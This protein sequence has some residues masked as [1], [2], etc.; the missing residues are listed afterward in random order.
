MRRIRKEAT[1]VW[2]NPE[3]VPIRA[4]SGSVRGEASQSN[5]EL[6]G[7]QAPMG[8]LFSRHATS[9]ASRA[10]SAQP[11][12]RSALASGRIVL[13]P[14]PPSDP[15]TLE[16]QRL[17]QRLLLA[18]GRP[19]VSKAA[20]EYIKAGYPLPEDQDVYLQ[21][22]EHSDEAVVRDAITS[23]GNLLAQE[24]P[25]RRAVLE[26]RL[27]RIEQFAEEAPTQRQAEQLRR[28]VGGHLAD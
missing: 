13:A 20:N 1:K 16:R 23:L 21:L 4:N 17:L 3:I 10:T 5:R 6:S 28:S 19:S 27:R 26:S 9:D 2:Y 12:T 15:A 22:L 18:E 8:A 14:P 24:P 7:A 25:K 11:R